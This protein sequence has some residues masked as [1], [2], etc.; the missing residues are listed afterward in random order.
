MRTE[1]GPRGRGPA[2]L[3]AKS[4]LVGAR[5]TAAI[6][7]GLLWAMSGEGSDAGTVPQNQSTTEQ[8]ATGD[9]DFGYDPEG[10]L[11]RVLP[12]GERLPVITVQPAAAQGQPL[13]HAPIPVSELPEDLKGEIEILLRNTRSLILEENPSLTLPENLAISIQD[14]RRLIQTYNDSIRVELE[15]QDIFSDVLGPIRDA[16]RE[17]DGYLRYDPEK[18]PYIMDLEARVRSELKLDP[19]DYF[20]HGWDG[21]SYYFVVRRGEHPDFDAVTD[22][23]NSV[24]AM[25]PV[26]ARYWFM[27]FTPLPPDKN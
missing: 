17:A 3:D 6:A 5:V 16:I 13:E 18:E 12:D 20:G 24:E 15:A 2:R 19:A 8:P 27:A 11:P 7:L 26:E 22:Y 21:S 9:L 14:A 1:P 23:L 10:R 25:A 4:V